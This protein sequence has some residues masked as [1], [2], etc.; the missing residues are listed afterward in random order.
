MNKRKARPTAAK[1]SRGSSE[2]A[3]TAIRIAI[4]QKGLD[5]KGLDLEGVTDIADY[6]V[7]VSGTSDRHVQGMADKINVALKSQ[8]EDPLSI[9]GYDRGEWVLMDYGDLV[10]HLFYEPIRQYYLFD[11]LWKGAKPVALTDELEQQARKLRTGMYR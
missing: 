3:L 11:E 5:V 9:S 8:G 1:N 6:F 7:I 2:A 10:V 4:E